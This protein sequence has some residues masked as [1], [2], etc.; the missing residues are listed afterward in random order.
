MEII[1]VGQSRQNDLFTIHENQI[2]GKD[3][4]YQA[5]GALYDVL[6]SEYMPLYTKKIC[7]VCGKGNNGADGLALSLILKKANIPF[8]VLLVAKEENLSAE[9]R[10]YLDMLKHIQAELLLVRSTNL[11]EAVKWM[12]NSD[13]IVDALLGT[14]LNREV[15]G[16]Y[17]AVIELMNR[18]TADKIS[19]DIASGLNGDNGRQMGKAVEADLTIVMQQY[20]YGNIL[21]DADDYTKRKIVKDIGI[22]S[23][24]RSD[25]TLLEKNDVLDALRKLKHNIHKYQKGNILVLGGS[26]GMEGALALCAQAV[27]RTGAGL[28]SIGARKEA[29]L[30]VQSLTPAEIML[31]E[32]KTESEIAELLHKKSAVAVGMGLRND[33]EAARMLGLILQS[34]LPVVLDAGALG[35]VSEN[36]KML[37]RESERTI[38][39]PHTA[40]LAALLHCDTEEI[41]N[42]PVKMAKKAAAEFNSTVVLKMNKTLIAAPDGKMKISDLGN[43]GMATAGSGDV[44]CGIITACINKTDTLFDAACAG[45]YLHALAGDYAMQK[46]GEAYMNAS[47]ITINLAPA[48]KELKQ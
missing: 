9:A 22:R 46:T 17:G 37:K 15:A 35:I 11:Q 28:V 23:E 27:L 39:T 19:V 10:Y 3:L 47:D 6:R 18:Q 14:G 5:A 32:L 4:V 21:N 1:S 30:R 42:N 7:I 45:V 12:D 20:K 29:Y 16:L 36:K 24:K 43:A 31:Y 26:R 44:L 34:D 8:K 33:G 38:L 48:L 13:V 40:E 25:V 2:D 41:R